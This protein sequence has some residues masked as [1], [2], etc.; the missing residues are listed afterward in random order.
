MEENH[1]ES[2]MP[3]A[4]SSG[5]SELDIELKPWFHDLL[6][7]RVIMFLVSTAVIAMTATVL[8]LSNDDEAGESNPSGQTRSVGVVPVGADE[9]LEERK[10]S[11]VADEPAQEAGGIVENSVSLDNGESGISKSTVRQESDGSLNLP[12]RSAKVAGCEAKSTGI[13]AW[14]SS[15]EAKWD[16]AIEDRKT[17]YFRCFIT[18]RSKYEGSL[19]ICLGDR[20]PVTFYALPQDTDFTE[21][22]MVRLGKPENSTLALI[23]KEIDPN[24]DLIITRVRLVPR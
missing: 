3:E 12:I 14:S 13:S 24:S 6:D 5:D 23:G 8:L 10:A 2:R 15:G 21:Q 9:D 22:V 7:I 1:T 18:Y 20:R 19:D 17:G 11:V 16:L 4:A